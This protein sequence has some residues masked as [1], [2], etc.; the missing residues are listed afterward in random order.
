MYF[1]KDEIHVVMT[2]SKAGDLDLFSI[3]LY[4]NRDI[5]NK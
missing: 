1:S 5:K 3:I 4:P 2:I